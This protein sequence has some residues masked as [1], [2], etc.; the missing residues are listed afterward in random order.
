MVREGSRG[1]R[2]TDETP[3]DQASGG[4]TGG[5]G[6][7][8]R[9]DGGELVD[10]ERPGEGEGV[11][12][13]RLEGS[14]RSDSE[15]SEPGE[16]VRIELPGEEEQVVAEQRVDE[17][18]AGYEEDSPEDLIA[19]VGD[20][21]EAGNV[22]ADRTVRMD[23][24]GRGLLS[25]LSEVDT[26]PGPASPGEL[27]SGGEPEGT[28]RQC[29]GLIAEF[30]GDAADELAGGYRRSDDVRILDGESDVD[31]VFDRFDEDTPEEIAESAAGPR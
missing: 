12:W 13:D 3:G 25:Y 27:G 4:G 7:V 24:D 31:R 30:P 17:V 18:F 11:D 6:P 9:T 8:L 21:H 16:S 20:G 10:W 2:P 29:G 15:R 5:E 19:A 23:A 14:G 1:D 26:D 22:D 28:T